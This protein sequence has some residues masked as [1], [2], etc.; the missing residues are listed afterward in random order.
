MTTRLTN[1]EQS[2][3]PR[4]S[5][6][7]SPNLQGNGQSAAG[8]VHSE[9]SSR[10]EHRGG[11]CMKS[12]VVRFV[13][14][15]KRLRRRAAQMGG[16]MGGPRVWRARSCCVPPRRDHDG[17]RSPTADA[18]PR[19]AEEEGRKLM[20][21]CQEPSDWQEACAKGTYRTARGYYK[22]IAST[23]CGRGREN[24]CTF[25]R[26]GIM[27]RGPGKRLLH[28]FWRQVWRTCP[29]SDSGI[30]TRRASLPPLRT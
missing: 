20:F 23:S 1:I 8:R 10:Q 2:S 7:L 6:W 22:R 9:I 18:L 28:G 16:G 21:P 5:E 14:F 19:E 24:N 12:G 15:C 26:L 30:R 3:V 4:T 11:L 13:L 25:I 29:R 27:G 17:A